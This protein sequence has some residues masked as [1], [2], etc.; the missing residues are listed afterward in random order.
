[1]GTHLAG[2]LLRDDLP[3]RVSAVDDRAGS[4]R[5]HHTPIVQR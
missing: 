2:E 4:H 1:M 5:H 3:A